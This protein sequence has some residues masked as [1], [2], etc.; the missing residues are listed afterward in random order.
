MT[1]SFP[2]SSTWGNETLF[3]V[4]TSKEQQQILRLKKPGDAVKRFSQSLFSDWNSWQKMIRHY[5][6]VITSTIP[7]ALALM[8]KYF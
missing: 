1:L 7:A 2:K 8:K 4:I 5:V 6:D 3:P